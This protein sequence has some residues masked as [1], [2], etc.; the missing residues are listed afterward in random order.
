MKR[1]LIYYICPFKDNYEWQSNVIE[2]NKYIDIFNNKIIVTIATGDRLED[3][4][5]VMETFNRSDMQFITMPNNKKTGEVEPFKKML[6]KVHSLDSCEITFYAHAKGVSPKWQNRTNRKYISKVR[7]WRNVMYYFCLRDASYIENILNDF[8]CCGCFQIDKDIE[9]VGAK[10]F[11]EG[12]FFWFNNKKLFQIDEWDKIKPHRHSIEGYLGTKIDSKESY[13]I[14][15]NRTHEWFVTLLDKNKKEWE[16]MLPT[17]IRFF[18][19]EAGLQK[20]KCKAC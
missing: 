20:D 4:R 2:L 6:E 8:S 3:P 1:N 15:L 10:W 14:I 16:E 19:F 13:P 7:V 17:D 18:N 5:V 9:G 12:T 11:Y